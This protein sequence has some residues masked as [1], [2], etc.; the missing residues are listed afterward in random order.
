MRPFH[1]I[2][3][4]NV[5]AGPILTV[6]VR[7]GLSIVILLALA[8]AGGE[9]VAMLVGRWERASTYR[10]DIRVHTSGLCLALLLVEEVPENSITVSNLSS[11][12]YLIQ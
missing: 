1:M 9:M 3:Q 10:A 11:L 4:F 8:R 5:A 6:F 7:A 2:V 12:N